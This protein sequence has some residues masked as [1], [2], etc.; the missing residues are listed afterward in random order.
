[1]IRR[2]RMK[3][4]QGA[5]AT[6][7][8]ATGAAALGAL[9]LGAIAVGA[10][11]VGAL[12]I[13]RLAVGRAQLRRVEI[14]ELSVGR[15][16]IGPGGHQPGKL[17]A[18]ARIRAAP[19]KGDAMASLLLDQVSLLRSDEPGILIYP[20]H[21]STSDPD[22]FLLYEQYA[23]EAAFERRVHAAQL[24]VFRQRVAEQGLAAGAVD[25]AIEVELY[26]TI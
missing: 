4:A 3:S 16:D 19:G 26:Q 23:D 18:V 5:I 17:I 6:G 14:G 11:A 12:A 1:M 22:L 21:R 8:H 25:G 24:D 20:P 9:A 10:M 2:A 13:G 7:A 15:L